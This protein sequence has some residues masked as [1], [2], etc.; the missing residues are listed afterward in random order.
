[1]GFPFLPSQFLIRQGAFVISYKMH[2]AVSLAGYS[3]EDNHQ[4]SCRRSGDDGVSNGIAALATAFHGAE[5]ELEG[6]R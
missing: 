3:H 2:G 1:M 5:L 6:F 4:K